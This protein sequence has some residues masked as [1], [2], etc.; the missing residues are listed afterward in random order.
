MLEG[1]K[2]ANKVDFKLNL[3]DRVRDKIT[4]F[5]GIIT[6]RTQWL[7][8]CNTYGVQPTQLKDGVPQDRHVFDEPQLEVVDK[9]VIDEH[10]S[11]GGP[12]RPVPATNR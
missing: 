1:L 8:N 12:E 11:T 10:R 3:G 9:K 2:K 7:H 6:S 5:S 4:G